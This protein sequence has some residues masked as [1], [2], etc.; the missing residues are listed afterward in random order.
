VVAV[1]RAHI[2]IATHMQPTADSVHTV[3]V[4]LFVHTV[5]SDTGRL[6]GA[7][8]GAGPRCGGK[9]GH[10]RIDGD[11]GV[12]QDGKPFS[13]TAVSC[14]RATIPW[15][16]KLHVQAPYDP[17]L[18]DMYLP[19]LQRHRHFDT[20]WRTVF[21]FTF[22][23]RREKFQSAV[24]PTTTAEQFAAD[25]A[26]SLFASIV[27]SAFSVAY[28]AGHRCESVGC[29]WQACERS[30]GPG[31]ESR[32]GLVRRAVIMAREFAS[33]RDALPTFSTVIVFF[34]K[35]HLETR[36][37]LLCARC[38]AEADGRQLT[39]RHPSGKKRARLCVYS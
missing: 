21:S 27:R 37:R 24:D 14:S 5:P 7:V 36:F 26:G 6:A 3:W 20:V 38:H 9:Q 13:E 39:V 17:L 4:P 29:V 8:P 34:L 12:F 22:G 2:H 23:R 1:S 35:Q 19:H 32:P 18:A 31:D 16:S 28:V 15:L 11:G 25:F 10:Q 33:F 30:H